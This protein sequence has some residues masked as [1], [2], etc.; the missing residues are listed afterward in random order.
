MFL[1]QILRPS[2][3]TDYEDDYK[4]GLSLSL[5]LNTSGHIHGTAIVLIYY[6][7]TIVCA[8]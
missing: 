4:K 1:Y 2:T 6:M 8:L 7:A 3:S 5:S